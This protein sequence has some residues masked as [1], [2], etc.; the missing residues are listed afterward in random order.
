MEEKEISNPL[1]LFYWVNLIYKTKLYFI[2]RALREITQ[3][4]SLSLFFYKI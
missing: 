4:I 3:F 1:R 2:I